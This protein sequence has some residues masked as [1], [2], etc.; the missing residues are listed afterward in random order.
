MQRWKVSLLLLAV[1]VLSLAQNGQQ[2]VTPEI[3]R[4]GQKLAC[5]C[6]SCKNT[7]ADCPML[8]CHYA[9]P[10]REVIAAKQAQGVSDQ[11]IINEFTKKEGLQ[12]LAVPP[13]EGFNVLAWVMPFAAIGV[14]LLAI[15]WF[16]RRFSARKAVPA[17]DI[18]PALL[19]RYHDEIEKDLAK[20]E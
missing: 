17:N 12:A 8:E 2:F 16:I 6:R 7:V 20:L 1:T 11:A 19:D 9:K 15:W 4:V 10:A 5:L 3:K 14:G 13:A 18:D